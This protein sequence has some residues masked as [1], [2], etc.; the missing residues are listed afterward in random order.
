M[1][2]GILVMLLWCTDDMMYMYSNGRPDLLGAAILVFTISEIISQRNKWPITFLSVLLLASGIQAVVCLYILLL[3]A[4]LILTDHRER[5][6]KIAVLS[7]LGTLLGFLLVCTFMACHSHLI[8]FVVNMLSYSN[9]LMTLAMISL[10][11]IGDYQGIDTALYLEKI[12]NNTTDVPL[13]SRIFTIYT[14]PAYVS[15]LVVALFIFLS[16][17]T[18]LKGS[19]LYV[20]MKFL[21]VCVVSIPLLMNIV[22]RFPPYY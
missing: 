6:K 8:A 20:M 4:Y 12:A 15:L 21:F 19:S 17:R 14:H 7:V 1:Q 18:N 16:E 13:Y 3:L 10:P 22:G 9:T 2:V 5:I 11:V